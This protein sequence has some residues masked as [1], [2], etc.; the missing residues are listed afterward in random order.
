LL[1]GCAALAASGC[2][3]GHSAAPVSTTKAEPEPIRGEVLLVRTASWPAVVRT[4][5]SLIADEVTIVG[6]KVTG[7]VD[8]VDVDLG[9][10]LTA[11]TPLATL[12]QADFRLQVS[13]AESQLMQ[14]RAALGL[15][16][17][18]PASSLNPE[19]APPV[20]EANA[21][22]AETQTR[23]ERLRQLQQRARNAVTQ[24]EL[25]QAIAAD[26]RMDQD[27]AH[28]G[29]GTTVAGLRIAADGIL[30]FNVGD[31]R[32]YRV[33]DGFLSQLSIDDVPAQRMKRSGLV[34]QSVGG[35]KRFTE[36]RPHVLRQSFGPWTYLLCS[37]GLYDAVKIED[38]EASLDADL[39]NAARRLL[40]RALANGARDNVSAL[41]VRIAD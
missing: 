5:G 40:E 10:V 36:I 19:N 20:R 27:A 29:M 37:D 38:M 26:D 22:W 30:V 24:E 18:D 7:R 39:G 21:V 14:A 23:V 25:D 31:S 2:G 41:L 4:Q 17:S 13:L 28:A 32:V 34:T 35:G 9:D 11:G 1:A 33:Q 6:A 15:R 16:P 8:E 3:D 12:N